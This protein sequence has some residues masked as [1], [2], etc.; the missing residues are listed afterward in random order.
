MLSNT[1]TLPVPVLFPLKLVSC[2]RSFFVLSIYLFKLF[3]PQRHWPVV[4]VCMIVFMYCLTSYSLVNT[5][6][7]K[8]LYTL[9]VVFDGILHVLLFHIFQN[10]PTVAEA[11]VTNYLLYML[12]ITCSIICN[13]CSQVLE[14]CNLFQLFAICVCCHLLSLLAYNHYITL[15]YIIVIN[16]FKEKNFNDFTRV[17]RNRTDEFSVDVWKQVVM[18]QIWFLEEACSRQRRLRWRRCN[19]QL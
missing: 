6:F 12:F 4:I 17:K 1:A 3:P 13:H 7:T 9:T 16:V 14:L 15:H 8:I 11:L 2:F 10:L 18:W 19:H 5:D